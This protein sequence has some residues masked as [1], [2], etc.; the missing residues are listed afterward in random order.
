M[1]RKCI[2]NR[3]TIILILLFLFMCCLTIASCDLID[4]DSNKT[5]YITKSGSKYHTYSCSTIKNSNKIKTTKSEAEL[6]GYSACKV[7]K[8]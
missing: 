8:P 7:C 6:L 5:V 2:T 1:K 4:I 3:K